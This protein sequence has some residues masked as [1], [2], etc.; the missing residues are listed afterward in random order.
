MKLFREFFVL[1]F[2]H[3]LFLLMGCSADL[4]YLLEESSE[5]PGV[6]LPVVRSLAAAGAVEV[7]W[8]N[9]DS[10]DGYKLYRGESQG[11]PYSP[12]YQGVANSCFDRVPEQDRIYYYRLSK[13]KG[14]RELEQSVAVAGVASSF[15]AGENVG[16]A[17]FEGESSGVIYSYSDGLTLLSRS[18]G[19]YVELE[20]FKGVR[21]TIDGL[22][23]LGAGEL[24]LVTAGGEQL[25]NEG[26]SFV[27]RNMSVKSSREPFRIEPVGVLNRAGSYRL[28]LLYVVQ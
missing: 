21:V 14:S 4:Y 22:A 2:F 24:R 12:V 13:V 1:L 7:S 6:A 17:P 28:R 15:A 25:L 11:G 8:A 27:I 18:V 19:Y 9:D 23:N 10:A 20:P 26:D 3:G 16:A 5:L